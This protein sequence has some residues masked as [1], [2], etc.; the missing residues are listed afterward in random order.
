[1]NTLIDLMRQPSIAALAWALIH[2]LWQGA[3]LGGAAFLILRAGRPQ[4]A[5]HALCDRRDDAG[6]DAG[7][8]RSD[9][10]HPRAAATGGDA[11]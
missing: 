7:D 10:H 9:V 6:V 3:L 2:F 4:R 1:M 11:G 8:M 5:C